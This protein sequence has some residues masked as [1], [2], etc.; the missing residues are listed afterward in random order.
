MPISIPRLR[1]WFAFLALATVA[2]VAGFYVYARW[3]LK[4]IVKE[5]PKQL[6]IEVQQSTEGFS[7]SKSEGGRTLFTIRASKAV[8]YKQGGRA[9]LQDVNIIVYGR[10]GDRFDQ[11]SGSGFEYDPQTGIV[12]ANGEV[13]IDLEANAL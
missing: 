12:R 13:N 9:E 10:E 1:T 11:I 8:Q 2:V 4:K 3:Q 6:G 7:L 5:A